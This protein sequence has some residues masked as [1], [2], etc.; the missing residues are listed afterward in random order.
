MKSIRSALLVSVCTLAVGLMSPL[1]HARVDGAS[2]PR[3]AEP[4]WDRLL[5]ESGAAAEAGDFGNAIRLAEEALTVVRHRDGDKHP[6]VAEISSHLGTLY[7]RQGEP[8]V[9]QRH[10]ERALR[11]YERLD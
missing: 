7:V 11:I 5:R 6:E 4:N 10:L 2:H 8:Y 1:S 9:A 3:V